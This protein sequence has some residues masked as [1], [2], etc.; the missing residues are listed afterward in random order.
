M[1]MRGEREE[2]IRRLKEYSQLPGS[3][4]IYTGILYFIILIILYNIY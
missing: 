2:I 3:G 1:E 4:F